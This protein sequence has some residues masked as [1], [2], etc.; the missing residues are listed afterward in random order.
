MLTVHGDVSGADSERKFASRGIDGRRQARARTWGG[1]L[2]WIDKDRSVF[3]LHDDQCLLA[4]F[5]SRNVRL[6]PGGFSTSFWILEIDRGSLC[7]A[8]DESRDSLAKSSLRSFEDRKEKLRTSQTPDIGAPHVN[9]L[10]G[11]TG[12]Y[13]TRAN[14]AD[15][16]AA[17]RIF[18]PRHI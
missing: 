9:K 13:R 18:W 10:P 2:R 12:S 4:R 15:A 16:F 17:G 14:C 7:P 11:E 1:P 5:L 8:R 6:P 3:L